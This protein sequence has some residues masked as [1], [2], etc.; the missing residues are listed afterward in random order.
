MLAA[1]PWEGRERILCLEEEMGH[2]AGSIAGCCICTK[3]R[4]TEIHTE[5]MTAR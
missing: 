4:E 1:S 3:Y 5:A 2:R